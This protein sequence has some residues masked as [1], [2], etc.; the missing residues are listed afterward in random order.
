[1]SFFAHATWV[2]RSVFHLAE[3]VS[4]KLF[5]YSALGLFDILP[6]MIL[7][8]I[9]SKR[10]PGMASVGSSW[11]FWRQSFL[12]IHRSKLWIWVRL[13][14]LDT[15]AY[16]YKRSRNRCMLK[17]P[18]S[19][20]SLN[21]EYA[22]VWAWIKFGYLPWPELVL[23]LLWSSSCCALI[24][25]WILSCSNADL[26]SV[27]V[28]PCWSRHLT[29]N[30]DLHSVNCGAFMLRSQL[31]KMQACWPAAIQVRQFFS[32]MYNFWRRPNSRV[33]AETENFFQIQ[34]ELIV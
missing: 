12:E 10:W 3:K 5:H 20:K 29:S 7:D 8:L 11:R 32:R 1:M 22:Q 33:W 9:K 19:W 34:Y 24:L 26:E 25:I 27:V 23:Q 16:V 2:L 18:K 31:Q 17:K 21:G 4:H 6:I 13:V 14:T 30:G 15:E 28:R